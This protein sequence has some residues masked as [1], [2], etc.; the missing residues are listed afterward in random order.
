MVREVVVIGAGIVGVSLARE[1][2]GLAGIRVT[3]LERDPGEPRGSTT[4]APGFVGLYN[5]APILTELAR[6][7]A[8][9]YE[10]ADTGFTRAGGLELAT[11]A[12]G[13]AEVERRA[14]AARA[15]GLPAALLAPGELPGP[16]TGFVDTE[17]VVAAA[18][19]PDDGAAVPPLLTAVLRA[20]AA[21]LGARF[22][23]GQAVTGIERGSGTTYVTTDSG[24]RFAADDVVL[25]GG[26]WGPSLA[27]L[28]G[29]DLPLFPVAHPYAYS[30]AGARLSAGPFVRWP[31]H[32]VYARVH[33][34][35]LG[36]GSYDH[37]PVLVGQATL[38]EGA[39][40]AW[41]EDFAPV[42]TSAQRLLRADAR[43]EPEQLV[44][45]VFAM[46]PD[47]LPFLGPHPTLPGVWIAQAIWVTHAAGAASRLAGALAHDAAPPPE[48]AVDRF[49]A[50]HHDDL[51]TAA[52]RLYR[53]IYAN[54]AV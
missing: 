35:R 1:L 10:K 28:T 48:L 42:I 45:G 31:E 36:I 22:V 6:A 17:Q 53:D 33:D 20:E 44:N 26:V 43:F 39:S 25:T 19:Y 40:L 37:P 23:S 9:V 13:A 46:T 4:Y 2:A 14:E 5:D 15:A 30:A 29:L 16:V 38:A 18:H 47:N 27:G 24:E 8:N 50:H 11:S 54:D 51:R 49:D 41:A 21:A 34:D 7:S 3:V 12:A 52:L 32:H